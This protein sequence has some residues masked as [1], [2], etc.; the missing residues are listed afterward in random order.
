MRIASY[1]IRKARGL[2]QRRAPDR[3]VEIIAGLSAD[4]VVLQEAD[5]R[6]GPR[7]SALPRQLIEEST[8]F[9]VVPLGATE[10]SLG[11]HGNAVLVRRGLEFSAVTRHEL[12]GLEPRGA[13]SVLVS[14]AA[15]IRILGVHLGLLRPY[16]RRQLEAIRALVDDGLGPRT[17]IAGDFNE[18]SARH[19]LTP[20]QPGFDLV[21]EQ[22]SFPAA[23]PVAALDRMA[24]G[25][26][27]SLTHFGVEAHPKSRTA[28]DHLPILAEFAVRRGEPRP[29]PVSGV[30]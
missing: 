11:W 27:L 30:D 5:L 2:D 29:T 16:R 3:I 15:Q 28:S 17:V 26:D 14:G 25:A 4:V 12:P 24:F 23:Y 18:W 20:L 9:Q 13:V 6:L 21:P 1:N 19:T 10:E 22:L 7:P 8:E